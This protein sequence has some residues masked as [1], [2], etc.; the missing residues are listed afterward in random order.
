MNHENYKFRKVKGDV[1]V[2][3]KRNVDLDFISPFMLSHLKN[4]VVY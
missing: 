4:K 2:S 3:H 1:S